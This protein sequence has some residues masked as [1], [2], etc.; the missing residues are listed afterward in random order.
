MSE[1]AARTVLARSGPDRPAGERRPG[2]ILEG[3]GVSWWASWATFGS[4]RSTRCPE[5]DVYL[6]YYQSPRGRMM[7][8]VRTAGDPAVARAGGA[9]R[10][11]GAGA[12][13]A[14][15]RCPAD[16]RAR[17]GRDGVRAVQRAPAGDVRGGRARAGGVRHV[18]RDLVRRVA[19]DEGDRGS[20]GARRDARGRA[21]PGRRSG[22]R[23]GVV[24][25]ALGLAGALA[26]TRVLASLLYGVAPSDSAD[27]GVD[28]GAAGGSGDR[29]EL[30]PARRAASVHPA[31]ALRG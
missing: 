4:G 15:L 5:P 19:A 29:G 7:M 17:G 28:R 21:A 9:S 23:A 2:R 30:L 31:D 13:R 3:H 18:R 1:T 27:A 12:R 20:R 8:F 14:A 6:S 16:A 22:R 11:R 25:G 24:G 26:T 10:D